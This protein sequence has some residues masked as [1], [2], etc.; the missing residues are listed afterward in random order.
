MLE[1]KEMIYHLPFIIS[2]F[3]FLFCVPSNPWGLHSL[4][5]SNSFEFSMA[6]EKWQ[7]IN[8]KSAL[9]LR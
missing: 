9:V 7:M 3:S 1:S 5:R 4:L 6:N 8:G 2:H